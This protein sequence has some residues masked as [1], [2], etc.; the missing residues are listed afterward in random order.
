MLF[1]NIFVSTIPLPAQ[2][3]AF[4]NREIKRFDKFFHDAWTQKWGQKLWLNPPFHLILQVIHKI[5]QDK[6]HAILVVP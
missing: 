3:H 2:Y 1:V 4:A 6:T 5:K